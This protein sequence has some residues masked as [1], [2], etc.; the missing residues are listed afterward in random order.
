MSAMNDAEIT[1]RRFMQKSG[2]TAIAAGLTATVL[3]YSQASSDQAAA[4][5]KIGFAFVGIGSLTLGE[6]LPA[7]KQTK[8]SRIAALVSGELDKAKKVAQQY[9]VPKSSCYTYDTYDRIADN[10]DVD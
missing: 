8:H 4:E 6:L 3:S 2:K 9:G 5:R 10:A 1:R 7:M